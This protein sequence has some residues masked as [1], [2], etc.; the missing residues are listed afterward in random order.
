MYCL[1]HSALRRVEERNTASDSLPA[2]QSRSI[3][4]PETVVSRLRDDR[5]K[6]C[7]P[8]SRFAALNFAL[9]QRQSQRFHPPGKRVSHHRQSH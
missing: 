1:L 5:Q 3:H 8:S 7:R 9:R 6:R 2:K 4:C